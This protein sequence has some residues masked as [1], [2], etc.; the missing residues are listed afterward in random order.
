MYPNFYLKAKL[1]VANIKEASE[2]FSSCKRIFSGRK[3][4][5]LREVGRLNPCNGG[6]A[7]IRSFERLDLLSSGNGNSFLAMHIL[8]LEDDSKLAGSIRHFLGSR[9]IACD[10][11]SHG[12]E[13]I[14]Q[15]AAKPYELYI[16]DINVPAPN[17]MEIC[18][19]IRLIDLRTPILML[20]AYSNVQTKVEALEAGADDYLVK[21]FH[22]D[23]LLARIKALR[24]RIQAQTSTSPALLQVADLQ[25]DVE[26][27]KVWRAGKE[28][29]LTPKE[30]KLLEVLARAEGKTISKQSIL[31]QVWDIN[32][33]TGTN[34]IEVYISF[35]RNKI[36]KG[37][38]KPL[39]H[40]RQ[41]YG[42]FLND[43]AGL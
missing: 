28:I 26:E 14:P 41:G 40:T 31:E 23:E 19:A 10:I 12:K 13:F 37:F 8:L 24:R 4:L 39:I 7:D 22:L 20:T 25:L 11:V 32:F 1:G 36:D 30:Y 2:Y 3:G 33:E 16:L 21:P 38:G 43:S 42:Y 6:F 5:K 29:S 9:S 27:K 15:L 17:G 35:L 18:K 34:T